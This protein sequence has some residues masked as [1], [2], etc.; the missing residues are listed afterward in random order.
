MPLT[1]IAAF[2]D[3]NLPHSRSHH[4]QSHEVLHSLSHSFHFRI[5]SRRAVF[6]LFFTHFSV[7]LRPHI[8]QKFSCIPP[9][10][11]RP[12]PHPSR[13]RT[14]WTRPPYHCNSFRWH[15]CTNIFRTTRR[16]SMYNYCVV[17]PTMFNS[18]AV[19]SPFVFHGVKLTKAFDTRVQKV[20][21]ATSRRGR[22]SSTDFWREKE[23]QKSFFSLTRLFL[24]SVPFCIKHGALFSIRNE[25]QSVHSAWWTPLLEQFW[26]TCMLFERRDWTSSFVT[27]CPILQEQLQCE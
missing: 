3:S 10:T 26:Q 13:V 14:L 21:N 16:T 4:S 25:R 12:Y 27:I 5:S 1:C 22:S 24:F 15:T 11:P 9:H 7:F 8:T 23:V 2:F 20:T 19:I 17:V 18:H 6:L